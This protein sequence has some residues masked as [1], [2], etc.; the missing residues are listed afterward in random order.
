[1]RSTNPGGTVDAVVDRISFS[2][3][4]RESA[5]CVGNEA[6]LLAHSSVSYGQSVS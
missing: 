2:F 5:S 3:C 4:R 6:R 1:M